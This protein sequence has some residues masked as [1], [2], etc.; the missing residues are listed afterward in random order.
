MFANIKQEKIIKPREGIS[1][2]PSF[3]EAIKACNE[4][5]QNYAK[6]YFTGFKCS[7]FNPNLVGQFLWQ[8]IAT[9][10]TGRK[11]TVFYYV[12]VMIADSEVWDPPAL[13][14][15]ID[16]CMEEKKR[17]MTQFD[18]TGTIETVYHKYRRVVGIE[19]YEDQRYSGIPLPIYIPVP[20]MQMKWRYNG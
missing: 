20:Q 14:P 19:W 3:D 13:A 2:K 11:E 1:L 10:R 4:W 15:H 9:F 17:L 6:T 12:G 16:R 7:Q 8:G 18:R 5:V